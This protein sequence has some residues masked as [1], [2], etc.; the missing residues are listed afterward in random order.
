MNRPK[1]KRTTKSED[2]AESVTDAASGLEGI[3]HYPITADLVAM[4][5]MS[6]MCPVCHESTRLTHGAGIDVTSS[7]G[8]G[9]GCVAGPVLGSASSGRP[10]RLTL[11]ARRVATPS[12]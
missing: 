11:G 6:L 5:G 4:P 1:R 9:V 7:S 2:L 10:K 8:R 3:N 12:C